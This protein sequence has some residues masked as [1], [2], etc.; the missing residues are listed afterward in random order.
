MQVRIQ[1]RHV[2]AAVEI[3]R[4][5]LE[6]SQVGVHGFDHANRDI[7]RQGYVHKRRVLHVVLDCARSHKRNLDRLVEKGHDRRGQ[8]GREVLWYVVVAKEN[9][10]LGQV[11]RR[12]LEYFGQE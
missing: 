2:K 9:R 12:V 11:L 1:A 4:A 8:L 5:L 6:L 3:G 7:Q 10:F